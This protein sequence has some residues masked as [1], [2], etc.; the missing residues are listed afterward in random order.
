MSGARDKT[1]VDLLR[2]VTNHI[3]GGVP[4]H[5]KT[6]ELHGALTQL[7]TPQGIL[8]VTSMNQL[9]HNRTFSVI[10]GD[11][12]VLFHNIYPLLEEMN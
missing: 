11:I 7:A 8:S 9:V 4:T 1:L 10:P 5:P 12:C 3:T 6:R 2:A